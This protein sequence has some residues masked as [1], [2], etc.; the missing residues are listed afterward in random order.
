[1][2]ALLGLAFL[3]YGLWVGLGGEPFIYCVIG[4]GLLVA[5]DSKRRRGY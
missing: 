1:M 2:L 5:E 3:L 4:I